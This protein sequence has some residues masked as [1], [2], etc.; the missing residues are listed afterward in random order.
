MLGTALVYKK[1]DR[2]CSTT[3]NIYKTNTKTKL[4]YFKVLNLNKVNGIHN[5]RR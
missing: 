5:L 3:K 2:V 4:F 1:T